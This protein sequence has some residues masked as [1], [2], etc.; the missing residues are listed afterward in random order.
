MTLQRQEDEE[1]LEGAIRARAAAATERARAFQAAG[2]HSR[3]VRRLRM[4]LP[5]GALVVI[6]AFVLMMVVRS[7]FSNFGGLTMAS[8]TVEGTKVTMDKPRLTS[9]R[10]DGGG[11]VMTA[12]R[13]IEDVTNPDEVELVNVDGD[14]G[15]HGRPPLKLTS[16][17]GH[18]NSTKETMDL[19][20]VVGLRTGDYRVEMT[21][22]SIDFKA[23]VYK[24]AEPVRVFMT[25]GTT[26]SADAAIA[27]DN[28]SL[29]TFVGHVKTS[30]PATQQVDA[31]SAG[32]GNG[33]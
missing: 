22:A 28:A 1:W 12:D 3:R 4:A 19:W 2:R 17:R 27:A 8:L 16:T 23:G 24:T 32:R 13:A 21:K 26:I 29:M 10:Q 6:A 9:A 25:T 20:G 11:Y 15:G 14:L 30:I 18:F 5:I 33:R 31:P 7:L